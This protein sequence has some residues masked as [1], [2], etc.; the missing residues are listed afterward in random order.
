MPGRS[1][2]K[3]GDPLPWEDGARSPLA[4]LKT[5]A[6]LL[7]RPGQALQGPAQ[8]GWG[9]PVVFAVLVNLLHV[10]LLWAMMRWLPPVVFLGQPLLKPSTVE[11]A[12]RLVILVPLVNLVG[13]LVQAAILHLLLKMLG[14]ARRGFF[15]S[16]RVACYA[17]A[18]RPLALL[19]IPGQLAY[20]FWNLAILALGLGKAHQVG[21]RL[22][23]AAVVIYLVVTMGLSGWFRV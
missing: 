11:L 3:P 22:P 23:L 2:L 13:V 5:W 4:L 19:G 7:A 21:W 10:I 6:W 8:G 1:Y 12:R 15:Q 18:P 20:L 17:Q 9:R 16:L 14:G